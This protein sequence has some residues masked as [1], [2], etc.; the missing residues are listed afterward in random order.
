M[1][2]VRDVADVLK[3]LG[4]V[5]KSTREI[6]N[7]VNDGKDYLK[8][9]FP[10]AQGDLVALLTQMRL[11]IVGLAEV[12][13]VISAFRF[14]YDSEN[15]NLDNA[16]RELA[17][18]NNYII[19]QEV[20]VARLKSNIS[21]LKAKCDKVRKLRDKLD[22]RTKTREWGSMFGLLG[23]KAKKRSFELHGTLSNFYADDQ[24]MIA[25]I[26]AILDLAELAI[27]DV[28][29]SLGPPGS[30]NPYYVPAAASLLGFYATLFETPKVQLNKLAADLE[31]TTAAL[32]R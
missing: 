32:S 5:V 16:T 20:L 26:T 13:K 4:D 31:A 2:S 25:H 11:T 27:E 24:R 1:V 6:V 12:A 29:N 14:A 17:R 23:K 9:R 28:N 3:M 7:A 15:V 10:D 18:F 22:A 21:R 19:A 8:T 30:A